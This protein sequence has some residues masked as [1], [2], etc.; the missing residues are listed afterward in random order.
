VTQSTSAQL[1]QAARET[2]P[3][4]QVPHGASGYVNYGCRC[5]ECTEGHR[6]RLRRYWKHRRSGWEAT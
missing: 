5:P 3:R 6:L 2:L 1:R 4:E